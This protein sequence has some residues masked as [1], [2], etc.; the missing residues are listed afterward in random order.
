MRTCIPT[1]PRC[2]STDC[3]V[4]P[5]PIVDRYASDD[6][7][8]FTHQCRNEKCGKTLFRHVP[9]ETVQP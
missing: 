1:C 8:I 7:I 9:P 3:D 5:A 2:D 6:K 4:L